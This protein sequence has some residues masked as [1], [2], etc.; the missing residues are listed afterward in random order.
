M[1]GLEHQGEEFELSPKGNRK[2]QWFCIRECPDK[3][4]LAGAWRTM[5]KTRQDV[6]PV[7]RQK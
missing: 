5:K 6:R 7:S 4:T 2:S 1:Q 3:I